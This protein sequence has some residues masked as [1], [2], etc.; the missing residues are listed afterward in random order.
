LPPFAM[1]ENTMLYLVQKPAPKGFGLPFTV[2]GFR[3]CFRDWAAETQDTPGEVVEMAL[4]HAIR[5]K[6]EAA[7]RRGAL[8]EKR[9]LLMQAWA[10][11]LL[12]RTN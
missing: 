10:N 7:Y 11:Y 3:S 4:A 2:H 12:G 5:N 9:R 1:S 8:I 6:A